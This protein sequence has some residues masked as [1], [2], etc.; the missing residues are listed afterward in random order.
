MVIGMVKG[1]REKV[2]VEGLPQKAWVQ[3]GVVDTDIE[4]DEETALMLLEEL[5]DEYEDAIEFLAMLKDEEEEIQKTKAKLMM[6][7]EKIAEEMARTKKNSVAI[8]IYWKNGKVEDV[9]WQIGAGVC[10]CGEWAY[11]CDGCK[12][13][14]YETGYRYGMRKAQELEW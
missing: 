4:V 6:H 13:N 11:W 2:K 3:Y 9:E 10:E 7:F 12:E 1:E 5:D 14:E 8:Y